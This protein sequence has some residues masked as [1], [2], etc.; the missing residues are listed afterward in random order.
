MINKMTEEKDRCGECKD[1]KIT[2]GKYIC[3]YNS[4]GGKYQGKPIAVVDGN[5]HYECLK[6]MNEYI[7]NGGGVGG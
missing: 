1:I 6:K 2:K 4:R 7:K 3:I 5:M